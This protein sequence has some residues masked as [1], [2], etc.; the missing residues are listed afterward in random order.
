MTSG[1]PE[2]V[3]ASWWMNEAVL[4]KVIH[5]VEVS[6][7]EGRPQERRSQFFGEVNVLHGDFTASPL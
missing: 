2:Q 4:V 3:L 5:P 7:D 6:R 1:F